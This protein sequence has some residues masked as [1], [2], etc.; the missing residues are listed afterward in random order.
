[1]SLCRFPFSWKKWILR[2]Y[3][4]HRNLKSSLFWK[5][6]FPNYVLF[7]RK[8]IARNNLTMGNMKFPDN[9]SVRRRIILLHR[10]VL[11]SFVQSYI[12]FVDWWSGPLG[13]NFLSWLT[14]DFKVINFRVLKIGF[15]SSLIGQTSFDHRPC[16]WQTYRLNTTGADHVHV[17][18]Y[19]QRDAGV[20]ILTLHKVGPAPVFQAEIGLSRRHRSIHEGIDNFVLYG[21]MKFD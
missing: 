19:K 11:R 17:F 8:C 18:S 13:S 20:S 4:A 12:Q 1:M 5:N 9:F 2:S 7:Q 14:I 21:W 15:G 6:Q 3:P 16:G 10:H